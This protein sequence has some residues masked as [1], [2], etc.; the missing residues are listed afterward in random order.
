MRTIFLSGTIIVLVLVGASWFFAERERGVGENDVISRSGLHWHARLSLYER[1]EL[2]DI[3]AN[4]G[5]G[6]VHNPVHTH[7]DERGLIHMEF[8]GLVRGR[9]VELVRFFEVWQRELP[10]NGTMT[11]NGVENKELGTYRMKDG[12]TIEIRYE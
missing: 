4:V 2:V 6:A 7:D 5:I 9:D 1:G 8:S 3:P 11:V 12:D 10:Q